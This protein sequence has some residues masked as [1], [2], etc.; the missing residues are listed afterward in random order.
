MINLATIS[1]GLTQGFI[2][3]TNTTLKTLTSI[4]IPLGAPV[5][6]GVPANVVT[7]ISSK[8]ENSKKDIIRLDETLNV[9]LVF[10]TIFG[11][12]LQT[13]L[14]LLSILDSAILECKS[15]ANLPNVN[16]D[17]LNL[18]NDT[19]QESEEFEHKDFKFKIETENTTSEYKR[20]RAIAIDKFGVAV[21]KTEF[22]Y[23]ADIEILINE[24]KFYIDQNNLKAE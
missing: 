23:S 13:I 16:P 11:A 17:L 12:L 7:G 8:I 22:S 3:I 4:P 10:L 21:L 14:S 9:V 18:I 24:L 6:V 5:G 2:A 19:V 15:N 20:R 1:I